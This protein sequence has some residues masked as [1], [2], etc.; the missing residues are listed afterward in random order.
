MITNVNSSKPSACGVIP[1][2]KSNGAC[3]VPNFT[4]VPTDS[5]VRTIAEKDVPI[6]INNAITKAL[7]S[8]DRNDFVKFEQA[9]LNEDSLAGITKLYLEAKKVNENKIK[10]ASF[11]CKFILH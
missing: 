3:S 5:F 4:S 10:V 1:Q 7:D 2:V 9:L 8:I 6:P 11:V